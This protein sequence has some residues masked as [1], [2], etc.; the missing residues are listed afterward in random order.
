MSLPS[1]SLQSNQALSD[2]HWGTWVLFYSC[3][4]LA[5]QGYDLIGKLGKDPG[6]GV[7]GRKLVTRYSKG[8]MMEKC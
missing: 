4:F 7:R 3:V 5:A 8:L 6:Y 2:L 1:S